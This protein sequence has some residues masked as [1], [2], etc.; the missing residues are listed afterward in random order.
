[1]KRIN[2]LNYHFMGIINEF[3]WQGSDE[4][5]DAVIRAYG[6]MMIK[7]PK[8]FVF[9]S[10]ADTCLKAG[11]TRMAMEVLE[12]GM[13]QH[14]HL[15]SAHLCKARVYVETGSLDSAERILLNII[16]KKPCNIYA[17]K[18]MAFIHLKTG[19]PEEGLEQLDEIKRIEP[20][21]KLPQP[22]HKKLLA[23][24]N[25]NERQKTTIQTLEKWLDNSSKMLAT[26]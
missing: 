15:L 25:R 4:H 8:S 14:P 3:D 10:M 20:G 18:L 2:V 17:R 7:N 23:S 13:K 11:K 5:H 22:L 21:H 12:K 24:T 1:M 26:R 6:K 16:R 19:R 9:V